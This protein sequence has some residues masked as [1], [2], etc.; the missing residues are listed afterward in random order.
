MPKRIGGYEILGELGRGGMGIVYRARIAGTD[1]A[2]ALKLMRD[3]APCPR[4]LARFRTEAECLAELDDPRIVRILDAGTASV[5]GELRPFLVMDLVPMALPIT[6]FVRQWR[7][8]RTARVALLADVAEAVGHAHR[9]GLIHR[10]LK[11]ANILVDAAGRPRIV[12]FGVARHVG[13][14]PEVT[15]DREVIGTVEWMSPEQFRDGRVADARSD[16]YALGLLAHALLLEPTADDGACAERAGAAASAVVAPGRLRER[17]RTIPH[18]LD[19]VVAMATDPDRGRRHRSA[20]ELA[21]DLRAVVDRRPIV[22]RPP[23]SPRSCRAGS[24]GVR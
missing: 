17:D 5:D 22:A 1:C 14:P 4:R 18:E 23:P 19:L 8:S 24:S 10:D 7:L 15:R 6:A 11:P 9:R 21:A 16:V 13:E 20:A 2:V 12:D 3:P